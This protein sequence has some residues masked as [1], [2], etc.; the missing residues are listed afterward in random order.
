MCR[1]IFV[2]F[3]IPYVQPCRGN[4]DNLQV[5]KLQPINPGVP[6][7]EG[8]GLFPN[9]LAAKAPLNAFVVNDVIGGATRIQAAFARPGYAS[10][11]ALA[12]PRGSEAH[13]FPICCS[14]CT[15]NRIN[16]GFFQPQGTRLLPNATN[17]VFNSVGFYRLCLLIDGLWHEQI[18]TFVTV[19]SM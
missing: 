1:Y 10:A 2:R 6:G 12:V 3:S 5:A 18:S 17:F 14:E 19:T 11:C 16:P 4:T 15:I 8:T 7:G 13:A 9:I